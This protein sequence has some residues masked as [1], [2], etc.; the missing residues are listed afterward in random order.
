MSQV[1][2]KKKSNADLPSANY[3]GLFYSSSLNAPAVIDE[4]G[5]ITAFAAGETFTHI[6]SSP[7]TTWTI[8]HNLGFQPACEI[9]SVGGAE[10]DAEVIHTSVNQTVIYFAFPVAGSARLN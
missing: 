8:N 9:F 1:N 5:V 3:V 6:Q 10:I 2:L 7:A 4:N